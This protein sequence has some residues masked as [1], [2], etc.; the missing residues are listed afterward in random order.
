V[1]IVQ[2]IEKSH[3]IQESGFELKIYDLF[4]FLRN[5]YL[6]TRLFNK[7]KNSIQ[8]MLIELNRMVQVFRNVQT[9]ETRQLIHSI[10]IL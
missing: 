3:Y 6:V 1:N 10:I 9:Q 7:K 4:L 2:L 5:E 8:Y